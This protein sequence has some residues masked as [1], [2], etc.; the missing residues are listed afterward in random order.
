MTLINSKTIQKYQDG[1]INAFKDI[2]NQLSPLI[3]NLIYNI[4]N[5]PRDAES[6]TQNVFTT[7]FKT[8]KK[9]KPTIKFSTWAYRIAANH[10][11]NAAS[12]HRFHFKTSSVVIQPKDKTD[13]SEPTEPS[14]TPPLTHILATLPNDQRL[15]LILREFDELSYHDISGILN[16]KLSTLKDQINRAKHT[17]KRATINYKAMEYENKSTRS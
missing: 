15:T 2:Y 6:L 16:V 11:L 13:L 3:Y 8:R 10:A 17:F 12:H 5:N 7:L 14:N 9:Y 1:N 4:V